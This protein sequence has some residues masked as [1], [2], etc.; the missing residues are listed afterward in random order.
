MVTY[1][2]SRSWRGGFGIAMPLAYVEGP[3][4][5]R[6]AA[7]REIP[8]PELVRARGLFVAEGRLV[9]ERLIED[10]RCTIHSLLLSPAA[11]RSLEPMLAAAIHQNT[12][13][14]V[15]KRQDFLGT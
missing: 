1:R 7:Y 13:F 9:V 2:L 15:S 10:A 8:E 3:D 6:V 12:Q 4:D 14:S 11:H 5:P